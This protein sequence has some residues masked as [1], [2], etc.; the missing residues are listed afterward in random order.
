MDSKFFRKTTDPNYY[1]QNIVQEPRQQPAARPSLPTADTRFPGYASTA[2]DGRL[3]TD[4]RPRC[5]QNVQAGSQYATKEWL[6]HNAEHCKSKD[7]VVIW[8]NLSEWAGT[9]DSTILRS[10]IIY[11]YKDALDREKK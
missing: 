6:I 9:A 3:L 1:A 4:Y 5:S 2:S 11:G 7:Y 8:N 10:K